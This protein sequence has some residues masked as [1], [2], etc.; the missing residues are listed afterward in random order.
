MTRL[1]PDDD[2]D[3]TTVSA[4]PGVRVRPQAQSHASQSVTSPA[5]PPRQLRDGPCPTRPF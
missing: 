3:V 4:L 1:K 5:G 2:A